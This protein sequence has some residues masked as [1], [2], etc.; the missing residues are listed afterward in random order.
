MTERHSSPPTSSPVHFI[1]E[2]EKASSIFYIKLV[3]KK[4]SWLILP[5]FPQAT[6]FVFVYY[7]NKYYAASVPIWQGR[8]KNIK[9]KLWL[10]PFH[11]NEGGTYLTR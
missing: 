10:Q 4:C 1:S 9:M 3:Q 11:T 6:T 2:Q 8:E 5:N 7:I